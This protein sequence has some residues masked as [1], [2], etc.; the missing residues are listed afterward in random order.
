MKNILTG[1]EEGHDEKIRKALKMIVQFN[2]PEKTTPEE[3]IHSMLVSMDDSYEC[4]ECAKNI[5]GVD[6]SHEWIERIVE[7][8]GIGKQIYCTIMDIV[9]EHELWESYISSVYEWIKGKKDE[10]KLISIDE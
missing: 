3:Y 2:L 4:V 8:M 7:Q 9:S 1:T 10:I 5:T 6:D